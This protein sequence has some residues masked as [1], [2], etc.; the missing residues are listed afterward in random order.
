MKIL[1]IEFSSDQ[2][3]AAVLADGRVLGVASETGTRATHAIGLVSQALNEAKIE[4]EAI[5]CLAVG[6]GPGSYTGV[7]SAIALAQGWQLACGSH[8]INLLGI[9]SVA[10]LA[11]EARTHGW[12]G[13]VSVIIDA[14]RKEFYL[15]GYE[16]NADGCKEVQ[17]LKLAGMEEARARVAA[18]ALMVG[19]EANRWFETGRALFP[20]AGTLGALAVGRMDFVSGEMLEPIYLREINFVKVGVKTAGKS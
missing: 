15:A 8:G 11:E 14:Q 19:P 16:I 20:T 9:S 6:L 3:S 7:R 4:R 18:G 2:R 5:E 13:A 1:A 10:C 12:F 17:P